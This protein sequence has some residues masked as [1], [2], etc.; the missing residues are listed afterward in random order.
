MADLSTKY[1]NSGMNPLALVL[2]SATLLSI[3][4]S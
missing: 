4:I 2:I 3:A 1:F